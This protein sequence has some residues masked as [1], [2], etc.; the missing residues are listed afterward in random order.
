MRTL[1]LGGAAGPALLASATVLCGWLRPG[2]NHGTEFISALGAQGTPG[3]T[4]MNLAGFI[5]SGLL[6]VGFA[7]AL[8]GALPRG[9]MALTVVV[10][11]GLFGAGFTA[12][13]LFSCDSGCP[14]PSL[15]LEGA[16]H[17]RIAAGMFLAGLGGVALSAV[18]FRRAAAFH[19]LWLYSALSA[20]AGVALL[21]VLMRSIDAGAL[22]GFW[23]RLYLAT[24]FAWCAVVGLRTF[25]VRGRGGA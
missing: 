6:L 8:R 21:V 15:S 17:D 14:N 3:A 2:Y 5:P 13:G 22:A 7:V 23:Q 19:G 24:L 10:L 11:L 4:L 16:A 20:V 12:A 25:Q 18:V 1:A 9:P